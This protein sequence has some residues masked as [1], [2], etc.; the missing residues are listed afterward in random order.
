MLNTNNNI[1][2]L[3]NSLNKQIEQLEKRIVELEKN[4]RNQNVS[5]SKKAHL[6]KDKKGDFIITEDSNQLDDYLKK[7]KEGLI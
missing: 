4:N 1:A 5:K 7:G 6:I 3:I 2:T